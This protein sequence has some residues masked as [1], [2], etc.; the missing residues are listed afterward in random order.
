MTHYENFLDEADKEG[1]TTKEKNLCSADGRIKGNKIAIRKDIPETQKACVLAEELGHYYLT[2][3]DI[4]DQ[5][6]VEN[7][8]QECASRLWGYNR[9][10]G[11]QGII[12]GYKASC[13]NRYELAKHLTVTEEFLQNALDCYRSKYG[14]FAEKDNYIIFFEPCL[15]VME[16]F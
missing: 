3:G 2:V 16:K 15:S 9:M 10:I 1:I 12:S 8:K 7:R 6:K 14:T 11:L 5:T 13:Q 4:S